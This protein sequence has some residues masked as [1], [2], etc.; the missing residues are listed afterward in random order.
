[1]A[2]KVSKN[3]RKSP[4]K[5]KALTKK[6]ALSNPFCTGGGGTD[7]ENS[8]AAYYLV[9]L[10]GDKIVRGL[11]CNG[12]YQISLQR[13][14]AGNLVDDIQ[15][16]CNNGGVEKNLYLQV[17]HNLAFS[18]N[19]NFK[20]VV[21]ECWL[22]YSNKKFSKKNDRI[23]IVISQ[24]SYI[25]DISKNFPSI[26]EMAQTSSSAADFLNK[27]KTSK[28]KFS[29]YKLI[30][31][32]IPSNKK[33]KLTGTQVF[34]FL[35]CLAIIPFEF[36]GSSARDAEAAWNHILELLT[37][38]DEKNAQFLF[39][40]LKGLISQYSK[41]GGTITIDTLRSKI[42]AK[43]IKH[44][45]DLTKNLRVTSGAILERQS[46]KIQALKN[47]K[48]YIPEVF[49]EIDDVKEKTRFFTDPT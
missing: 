33:T 1:M 17:K 30:K 3:Y 45:S 12:S 32:T 41:S 18:K 7:Y 10:I 6:L 35:K 4:V 5:K 28:K 19:Q 44:P 46:A 11:G 39:N 8:V 2:K 27:I 49:I 24:G 31:E 21:Q 20:K 26:F 47:S 14:Y 29:Y 38:R 42:P 16:T 25:A 13:R 37:I 43:L 9:T 36:E 34:D 22:D 40:G 48:K 15:V 23:G